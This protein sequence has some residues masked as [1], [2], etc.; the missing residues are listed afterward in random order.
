MKNKILLKKKSRYQKIE[1]KENSIFGKMLFLDNDLQIAEK[2]ADIYNQAIIKP[3]S[4]K[5]NKNSVILILGGGSGGC[6]YEILKYKP[7]LVKF[8]DIDKT[9]VK[10]SKKNLVEIHKNSFQD[11]KVEYIP[12]EALSFLKIDTS[13]YDIIIYSLTNTPEK[14]LKVNKQIFL[15]NLFTQC[16][17]HLKNNGMMSFQCGSKYNNSTKIFIQNIKNIFKKIII[18]SIFIPSYKEEWVFASAKK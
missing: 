15:N 16:K 17:N 8:V 12:K 10:I 9:L 1:I 18:N 13:F 7:K 14:F 2:D 5:I 6:I 4:K 11:R 3:I